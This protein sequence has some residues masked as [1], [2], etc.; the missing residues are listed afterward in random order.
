MIKQFEKEDSQ[1]CSKIMLDCID[2]NLK[3]L[4][5]KNRDFMIKCSQPEN[6][7]EKSKEVLLFVYEEDGKIL[8]TGAFDSGEIRTMFVNPALQ[9]KGIGKQILKFLI[10]LAKSKENKKVFLKSSPEAEGFY[11][12]Q[13]F[14][15]IKE[16]N[17]FDFR[18]IE[19][20][21]II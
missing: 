14:K 10:E 2:K 20:E 1:K 13:G 9:R 7:I 21:K 5:K 15:K 16:N 19:M 8:G 17:D 6:L 12:K 3:S 4:T 11:R 18:T